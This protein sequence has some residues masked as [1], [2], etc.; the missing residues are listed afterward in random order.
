M[1]KN[2]SD[3]IQGEYVNYGFYANITFEGFD[4]THVFLKDKCGNI[5]KVYKELFIKDQNEKH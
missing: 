4:D 2:L 5:K 3:Y 1:S